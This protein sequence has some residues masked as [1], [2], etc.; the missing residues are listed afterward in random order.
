M[1]DMGRGNLKRLPLL[2]W[3]DVQ[4][5]KAEKLQISVSL[6]VSVSVIMPLSWL[7][8]TLGQNQSYTADK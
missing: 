1:E 4:G 5:G 8:S 7:E 3:P 2:Q 6:C